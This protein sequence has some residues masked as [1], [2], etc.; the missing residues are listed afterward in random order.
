[1]K[2]ILAAVYLSSEDSPMRDRYP[3]VLLPVGDRPFIHH[4]IESLIK[5]GV[6][7]FD[8]LLCHRPEKIEAAIGNGE[9]WGTVIRT[10]LVKDE[11][12]FFDAVR[13]ILPEGDPEPFILACANRLPLLPADLFQNYD[14]SRPVLISQPGT[15]GSGEW[16]GWAIL[17]RDSIQALPGRMNESAG[18]ESLKSMASS[19]VWFHSETGLDVCT[20]KSL[21]ESNTKVIQGEMPG[22][23]LYGHEIEKGIWLSRNVS[24]HPTV[25]LEPPVYIGENCGIASACRLG[26][27]AFIGS[28]CVLDEK[29][30]VAH[31]VIFSSTY[32]GP[33]LEI[34]HS[35]VDRNS[36]YNTEM[37]ASLVVT[38]Q[39]I[40]G[41]IG[42]FSF[43]KWLRQWAEQILAGLLLIALSPL[44]VLIALWRRLVKSEPVFDSRECLRL[45][46]TDQERQWRSFHLYRFGGSENRYGLS[47]LIMDALP[48]LINIVKG[49]LGFAGVTPHSIDFV[50]HMPY[51]WRLLYLRAKAGLITESLLLDEPSAD[52]DTLYIS[53]S[54]YTANAGFAYDVKLIFRYIRRLLMRK[55]SI[56]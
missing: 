28:D 56:L 12:V 55:S 39:F 20:Y 27:H 46:A 23:T 6:N 25:H 21:I 18:L 10:H 7:E 52:E 24:L 14:L 32:I 43:G 54:V 17:T 5:T 2:A 29:N 49:D 16:P 42:D 53:D 35:V 3:S 47:Y 9:R 38:E 45:P 26:P 8:L 40:L 41:S 37:D 19:P 22:L 13:S 44:L 36:L 31:A 50:K 51:D 4:V 11:L 1:M 30:V 48:G 33:G 34:L 15:E